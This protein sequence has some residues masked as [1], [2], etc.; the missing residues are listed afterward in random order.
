MKDEEEEE[1]EVV[2]ERGEARDKAAVKAGR[3]S[4]W[5]IAEFRWVVERPPGGGR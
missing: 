3:K 5:I 2:V 4:G 1:E